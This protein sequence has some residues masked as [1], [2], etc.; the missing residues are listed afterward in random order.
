MNGKEAHSA[1]ALSQ[2]LEEE[3]SSELWSALPEEEELLT[4]PFLGQN[5]ALTRPR[6]PKAILPSPAALRPLE[7]IV[8]ATGTFNGSLFQFFGSKAHAAH[9]LHR[10]S[11]ATGVKRSIMFSSISV[12]MGQGGGGPT[13]G[14]SSFLDALAMWERHQG[15]NGQ[16]IAIEWGAIGEI[17]LRRKLYGTRDV[18]AQYDLGQKLISPRDT[19]RLM[20]EI[21][22]GPSVPEL[23][24]LAWLDQNWQNQLSVG[25]GEIG[26]KTEE[27]EFDRLTFLDF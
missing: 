27:E 18:F 12:Y 6:G 14:A 25:T 15:L 26:P 21:V 3:A 20:R 2:H 22:R 13:T 11:I 19:L 8:Q 9:N 4:L 5:S 23:I 17:G 7:T 10:L 24:G 16:P 1:A